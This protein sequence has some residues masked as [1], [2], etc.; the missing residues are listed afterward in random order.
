MTAFPSFSRLQ[1]VRIVDKMSQQ[2]GPKPLLRGL[3]LKI[4]GFHISIP[5]LKD[6]R[7][8]QLPFSDFHY[9]FPAAVLLALRLADK[10]PECDDGYCS[11]PP[12]IFKHPVRRCGPNQ[13]P[14]EW[15]SN[16]RSAELPC[17]CTGLAMLD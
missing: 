2:S 14:G 6:L 17:A 4:M 7:L 15:V 8:K 9:L 11:I 10:Q 16:P 3:S 5:R 13:P 12:I 1:T